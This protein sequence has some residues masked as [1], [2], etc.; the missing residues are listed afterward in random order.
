MPV[1]LDLTP[2]TISAADYPTA[3]TPTLGGEKLV[4]VTTRPSRLLGTAFLTADGVIEYKYVN[5]PSSATPGPIVAVALESGVLQDSPGG[6]ITFAGLTGTFEPVGWS[7]NQGFDF[8]SGRAVELTGTYEE[9]TISTAPTVTDDMLAGSKFALLE[10]PPLSAFQLAGC[11][12]DRRVKL[13]A[14]GTKT[15][16][17]G[18]NSAEW[19]TPGRTT[20]GELEVTGLN[21]GADD[22]LLRYIGLK[23]QAMLVTQREGRLITQ[24]D[25]CTDWTPEADV[26]Y[27]EGDGESTV[28]LRGMYSR[29]AVLPAP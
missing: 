15:I 6:E 2:N 28:S 7:S 12:N 13:P 9:P 22:G 18:L 14:R 8:P 25:F 4:Y 19:T 24:R 21:Q 20:V 17:C 5:L 10:L 3:Q 11:T 29:I 23:C 1:S 27:P 26:N 16:P